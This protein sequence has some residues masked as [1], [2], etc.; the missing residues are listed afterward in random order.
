LRVARTIA[1]R[2]YTPRRVTAE[3]RE[4]IDDRSYRRRAAEAAAI[5]AGEQGAERVAQAVDGF[6]RVSDGRC[7]ADAS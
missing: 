3:I 6:F 2:R 4:L 5:V 7:G 1:R